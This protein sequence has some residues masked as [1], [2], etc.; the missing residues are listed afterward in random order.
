M[1]FVAYADLTKDQKQQVKARRGDN[2][3]ARKL[4]AYWVRPDGSVAPYGMCKLPMLEQR[5]G[6]RFKHHRTHPPGRKYGWADNLA[7]LP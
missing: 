5:D 7:R 1:P 6:K 3:D 4:F 2:D